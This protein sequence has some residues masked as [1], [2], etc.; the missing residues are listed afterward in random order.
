[1]RATVLLLTLALAAC[2]SQKQVTLRKDADL[3]H[4]RRIV[5]LPFTDDPTIPASGLKTAAFFSKAAQLK[6]R[7]I[8]VIG[9]AQVFKDEGID[10]GGALA[11]DTV[12][13]APGAMEPI[14]NRVFA[15]TAATPLLHPSR[16]AELA[17][18]YSADAFVRG[19][20]FYEP[21]TGVVESMVAGKRQTS[22]SVALQMV[23][24][25]S[26]QVVLAFNQRPAKIEERLTPNQILRQTAEE[27]VDKIE[28]SWR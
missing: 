9:P 25:K 14:L 6:F 17:R 26:G 10:V 1:M 11:E 5:V 4:I 12:A 16:E 23:D 3:G 20:V 21:G 13:D 28:R 2:A 8:Q 15:S 27:A 7:D 24:T 19:S 22:A 18:R